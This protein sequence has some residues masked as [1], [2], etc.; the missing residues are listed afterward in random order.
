MNVDNCWKGPTNTNR[1]P[2][3]R[4]VCSG[5]SLGYMIP[6]EDQECKTLDLKAAK[7]PP[8][9]PNAIDPFHVG[10]PQYQSKTD[11]DTDSQIDGNTEV[12]EE[13]GGEAEDEPE[14]GEKGGEPE[15]EPEPEASDSGRTLTLSSVSRRLLEPTTRCFP[16]K[17]RRPA[18]KIHYVIESC[19]LGLAKSVLCK[20]I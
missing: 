12:V 4:L 13:K 14:E 11:T 20:Y 10:G 7:P 8:D 15:E 16:V 18:D 6:Y 19:Y 9:S 3:Y 2:G 17:Q 5:D 1:P